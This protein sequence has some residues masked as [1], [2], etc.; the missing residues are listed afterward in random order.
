MSSFLSA[1][2]FILFSVRPAPLVLWNS[3]R[4]SVCPRPVLSLTYPLFCGFRSFPA[5]EQQFHMF[6]VPSLASLPLFILSVSPFS[7]L[8]SS[9]RELL[10]FCGSRCASPPS[11]ILPSSPLLSNGS[12]L[13]S[14]CDFL[15][16]SSS[17][18][19]SFPS[20]PLLFQIAAR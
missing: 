8:P 2:S 1:S 12:E 5:L 13:V 17:I 3:Y 14:L 6:D 16:F 9:N 15:C 19:F 10:L 7:L 18:P 4:C 20:S 11:L